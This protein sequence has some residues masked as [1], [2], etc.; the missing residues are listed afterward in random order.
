MVMNGLVSVRDDAKLHRL[1]SSQQ[2]R[3]PRGSL[4]FRRGGIDAQVFD[5]AATLNR[6]G[7][8]SPSWRRRRRLKEKV[9]EGVLLGDNEDVERRVH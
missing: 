3:K 8:R 2:Q 1:N 7:T 9:G 6:G 5:T 4:G